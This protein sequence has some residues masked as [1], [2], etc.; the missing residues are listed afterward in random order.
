M[1]FSSQVS[2]SL[3]HQASPNWR[4]LDS[5]K[6]DT[7]VVEKGFRL[8]SYG[9]IALFVGGIFSH[10]I[11]LPIFSLAVMVR[12]AASVA[13]GY[14][15]YPATSYQTPQNLEALKKLE[16]DGYCVKK[17]QLYKSGIR[18]DA[19]IIGHKSTIDNGKW[20]IHALGNGMA[21]EM[22]YDDLPRKNFANNSNTLLINGPSVGQSGGWP[23]RYQFGAGFEA[24]L[25]FLEKQ[26]D[27][28]HIV[29]HGLSL[30]GGMMGEAV[31]NH[32]FSYG[33]KRGIKYLFVA[34]RT[35]SKLSDVAAN[36]VGSVVKPIFYLAGAELD[37]VSA[38]MRL[39]SKGIK[40]IVIQHKS[41]NGLGSD[42]VIADEISLANQLRKREFQYSFLP[43]KV[44]LE[45]DQIDHNSDLPRNIE[46][47]LKFEI[48]QF[49]ENN[50][51]LNH[52]KYYF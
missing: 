29:M 17:I 8:A 41:Q 14:A 45:S 6:A 30:G 20:T 50:R 36:L 15:V 22:F 43:N 49:F 21:M 1:G 23:T 34:D 37:G 47:R 25:Q 52:I 38:G 33:E 51:F 7:A 12:K 19:A 28:T 40:Q 31:L 9:N 32:D 48:N 2:S 5:F 27:A 11:A 35:F 42:G 26:V 4:D 3:I 18:Y 13:I 16:K 24:G 46:K 39:S 44:Y 10:F